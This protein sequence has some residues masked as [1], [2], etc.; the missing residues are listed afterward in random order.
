M[1]LGGIVAVLIPFLIAGIII[2]VQISNSLLEITEE[3]SLH[4]ANDISEIINMTLLQEIKLASAIAADPDIIAASQTGDYREAQNELKQIYQRIGKDFFTIFLLDK[5]GIARAEAFFSEQIGLDLSDRDYFIKAKEGQTT[6]AGPIFARG[7]ATP[8][9]SILLV[10]VPIQERG[11]FLGVVALAFNTVFMVD[12]LSQKNIG[13]MGFAFLFNAEGLILVHPKKELILKWNILD[14]PGTEKIKKMVKEKKTGIVSYSVDGSEKILG[15]ARVKL[16]GWLVAFTQSRDEIMIPVKKTLTSIFFSGLIFLSI[17]ILIII[18][19]YSKVSYSVQKT[20]EMM[21]HVTHYSTEIILQIGLDKKIVY[22]NPTF[23]KVTGLK[24]GEIIG[25]EIALDNLNNI[26]TDIIWD[27]LKAG[28]PWSGRIAFKGKK[29]YKITLDVVILPLRDERGIIQ[30]YLEI[31]RDITEELMFEKRSQQA[32]K[33]EAIGTLVGGIAHDF[34]NILSGIFGYAELCLMNPNSSADTE[35]YLRQIIIA[36]ERARDLVSQILT[37]S[38]KTEFKS[39]PLRP[40]YILHEAFKLLR[41][42]IPANIDIQ[43]MINSDSS[44][45]SDPTQIYQIVMNLVMNA[46]QAI[47]NKNGTIKIELEDFW[48]DEEFTN[49]HPNITPGKHV[50]IRIS[51]TGV[52]IDS[53]IMDHIFEPFFT[54]KSQE[55][56]TGLGLSVVHGIVNKL[57]GIITVYSEIGKGTIFNIIIPAIGTDASDLELPDSYIREGT[58][59]IVVVDDEVAIINSMRIILSHLGYKVIAYTDSLEALAAIEKDPGDFDLIITD[60]SMPRLNGLELATKLHEKGINI[61]VILSSGY[62]DK[63]I[64]KEADGLGISVLLAKP[65]NTYHLTMAIGKVLGDH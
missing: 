57:G 50:I 58:E 3:R 42:S 39:K 20:L 56:G 61:P 15:L 6:V 63:N 24:S 54:T 27:S 46:V 18:F 7:N 36:S 43:T 51:D 10:A 64:E 65:I 13:K 37:F 12:I 29:S 49:S 44:I 62:F 53:E 35:K 22:V 60:Y 30:G 23:E 2:Y 9:E 59:R 28:S 26:P 31:G 45:V 16:T 40:K 4:T 47:G 33:L 25:S 11:D 1:I 48:V 17:T 52:G 38:R 5:Y 34:N 41:A 14:Q 19:F 21:K 32:Q 55:K 8:G